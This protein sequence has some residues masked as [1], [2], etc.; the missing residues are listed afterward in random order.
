M[1]RIFLIDCV[2]TASVLFLFGRH[3]RFEG[4]GPISMCPDGSK[5]FG[6]VHWAQH[7]SERFVQ[8]WECVHISLWPPVFL[9]LLEHLHGDGMLSSGK[10]S[11]YAPTHFC[12]GLGPECEFR[13][14]SMAV[15][16]LYRPSIVCG[17]LKQG[18]EIKCFTKSSRP[19]AP[20]FE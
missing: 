20:K 3:Y 5:G 18:E 8:V 16:G 13:E 10:S 11:L 6:P 12:S 17:P 1:A 2:E 14:S 4:L 9:A 15:I 19:L 7:R